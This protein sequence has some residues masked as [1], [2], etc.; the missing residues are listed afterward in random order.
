MRKVLLDDHFGS[1]YKKI[2]AAAALCYNQL[3]KPKLK[4]EDKMKSNKYLICGIIAGIFCGTVAAVIT[5]FNI[6]ICT[7]IATLLGI[8]AGT[9]IDYEQKKGSNK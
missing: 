7:G 3:D 1:F 4:P 6:G 9:T 2:V 8:V 5:R